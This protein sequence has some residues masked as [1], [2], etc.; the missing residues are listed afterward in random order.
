M[1]TWPKH[2]SAAQTVYV[3]TTSQLPVKA[4][5]THTTRREKRMGTFFSPYTHSPAKLNGKRRQKRQEGLS[6]ARA[7]STQLPM[8]HQEPQH[9]ASPASC[10]RFM[11]A[12]AAHLA[13][14]TKDNLFQA[15]KPSVFEQIHTQSNVPNLLLLKESCKIR[16]PKLTLVH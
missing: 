13:F 4:S 6:T 12:G 2:S 9:Q 15:E 16:A 8:R 1:P 3:E 5:P 7:R 10:S 14:S 11:G